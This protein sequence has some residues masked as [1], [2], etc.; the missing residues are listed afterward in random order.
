MRSLGPDNVVHR[1]VRSADEKN[2]LGRYRRFGSC[3]LCYAMADEPGLQA[4]V[5][6]RLS[7]RDVL[8]E[9][10]SERLRIFGEAAGPAFA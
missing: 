1:V 7:H 3:A 9:I 5:V 10:M 2:I 8:E 6:E 4:A